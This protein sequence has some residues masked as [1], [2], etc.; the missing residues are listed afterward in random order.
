MDPGRLLGWEWSAAAAAAR[1]AG[2]GKEL[3]GT[4]PVPLP[5]S[6]PPGVCTLFGQAPTTTARWPRVLRVCVCVLCVVVDGRPRPIV[7]LPRA[8]KLGAN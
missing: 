1:A 2:R 3:Q 5:A 7:F 6:F 4:T 8:D